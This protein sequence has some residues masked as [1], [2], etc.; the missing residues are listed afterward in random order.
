ME[1]TTSAIKQPNPLAQEC[2]FSILIPTWNN[3]EYLKLCVASIKKN[4]FYTHQIIVHVN[5]G[6]DGTLEWIKEQGD[7]DYSFSKENVGVCY[8][9]NSCRTLVKTNY[10]VY[11]NDDMYTCPFWDKELNNEIELIGHKNFFLSS[12]AIEPKAQSICS[13]EKNYG[14]DIKSFNEKKLLEEFIS[15]P[16]ND[17][18][19]ATWPPN[20]VHR[21][22][23]DLAG[24]YSIEFSPGM[25]S[26]P[27][28]SMKLWKAGVRIFKGISMSRVYHFGSVSVKRVKK[29]KGYYTFISKW[30]ITSSTL[31]KYYLHR[32]EKYRDE[33]KELNI[34]NFV[35]LKNLMKRIIAVFKT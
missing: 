6:A 2:K 30:G 26:D 27:D 9:L 23:W 15:L 4:S 28:F 3:L 18:H 25:Y 29:N 22:I 10:I 7:I 12:T 20:I 35:R 33:L 32:G 8:A 11:M 34:S 14:I 19:G 24:G 1:I 17:W 5:E 31:S 21:D 13:I 16:I